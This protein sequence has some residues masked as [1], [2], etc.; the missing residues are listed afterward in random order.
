MTKFYSMYSGELIFDEKELFR[1]INDVFEIEDLLASDGEEKNPNEVSGDQGFL[2]KGQPTNT[3]NPR[4]GGNYNTSGS[5]NTD[6][7][8]QLS[9]TEK[10]RLQQEEEQNFKSLSA[11]MDR[12][13][14]E[15]NPPKD[16]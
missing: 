2:P 13:D 8:Q 5:T 9:W 15:M 7:Q 1:D 12:I 11:S 3:T 4:D 6:Q 10:R 14:L 16:R